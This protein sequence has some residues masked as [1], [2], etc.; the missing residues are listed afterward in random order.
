MICR[1][2]MQE[3]HEEEFAEFPL[4]SFLVVGVAGWAL[5]FLV[6]WFFFG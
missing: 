1:N 4:G 3:H 5:F 6:A 2:D